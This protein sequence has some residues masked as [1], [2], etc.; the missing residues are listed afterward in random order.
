L[1]EKSEVGN[2]NGLAHKV[3]LA[4]AGKPGAGGKLQN[5]LFAFLVCVNVLGK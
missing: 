5:N 1:H 2:G 3:G 4:D